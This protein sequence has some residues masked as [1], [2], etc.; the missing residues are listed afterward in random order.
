[1]ELEW[2]QLQ[3]RYESVRK[4][5]PAQERQLLASLAELGQQQPIVV[6][7][8]APH[9]VLIDGYKRVRALK[10][11]ARDT[12]LGTCWELSELE[13]LLLERSLRRASEDALDQ[14]WLLAT[15]Q[16]RFGL[17]LEE[18][19]RRFERS[20]SWVS[21]RLALI[22]SLPHEIQEHVRGGVLSAHVA[23]KYLV[24]LAR[25]N[26][27]AATRLASVMSALKPTSREVAALY[28]GW[29]SGTARTRELILSNPQIYLQAQASQAPAA[30]S[31]AQRWL[32]DVSALGGLARR[33]RRM[34]EK[35]L[36]QQLVSTE[37]EELGQAFA[38]M[39]TEVQGLLHRFDLESGHVG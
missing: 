28:Q 7:S 11:L 6:V 22:Q 35:G 16:E 21:R 3:M 12:V 1:M 29:R 19:A 34:L 10:R 14:G 9:F 18:L 37:R 31:A 2:H 39:K 38:H 32:D 36:W 15:L 26:A 4:R 17:S 24:P 8:D 13:A 23:M 20:K 25:A 27:P 5:H 33:S 30:P